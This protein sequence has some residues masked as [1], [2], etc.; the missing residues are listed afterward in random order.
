MERVLITPNET[1]TSYAFKRIGMQ[2][3][4]HSVDY[5]NIEMW[6]MEKF[7]AVSYEKA[8]KE[9][10]MDKGDLLFW[11]PKDEQYMPREIDEFGVITME[12]VQKNY[13]F[14]VIED[15]GNYSDLTRM[16]FAP[17]PSLQMRKLGDYKD[18]KP[19]YLLKVRK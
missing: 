4:L 2:G 7:V 9:G 10:L 6:V 1:C 18:R 19:N 8:I 12:K 5:K 17:F 13:H 16:T 3:L 14:A 15:R 11:K